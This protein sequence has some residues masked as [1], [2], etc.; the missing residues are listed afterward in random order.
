MIHYLKHSAIDKDRWDACIAR[1][2][3]RRIYA[4]SWYLDIVCPGWEALTE[5]DYTRVFPLT[6]NRKMGIGYLYQP[7]FTQQLGLFSP[8]PITVKH[9]TEFIEAIPAKFRFVEIQLNTQNFHLPE[10]GVAS[11][12]LNHE[13][14]LSSSYEGLATAY[15][16]NTRRNIRKAADQEVTLGSVVGTEDL[17]SLFRENFGDREGKLSDIHYEM[18]R[19]I[20]NRCVE[21]QTGYIR[22]AY[23]NSGLLS[24]ASF[25]LFDEHRVYFLFAASSSEAR[26]NGAMFLLIDRFIHDH[27]QKPMILDFEGGNE[28]NLGRFYK[29]FGAK[30]VAYPALRINRLPKIAERALYFARKIRQR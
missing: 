26:E 13:L 29:S 7:F 27:A 8:E 6:G 22:G 24:A 23:S 5:D 19:K 11:T 1:S 18:I 15:A 4:F 25:F 10:D 12:R 2:C 21:R 28:P 14:D 30:E 17:I 16:Q 9:V 20:I 3:N